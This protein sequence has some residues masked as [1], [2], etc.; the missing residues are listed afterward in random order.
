MKIKNLLPSFFIL[1]LFSYLAC[2]P[3]TAKVVQATNDQPATT[4]TTTTTTTTTTTKPNKPLTTEANETFSK[5]IPVD[6]EIRMGTLDNGL[7]YYIKKN[8][9]PENR[10]ELRLALNAGAMQ[11][12]DDQ[13]VN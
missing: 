3:K 4:V 10:A 5:R 6:P 9:K 13:K 7:K 12:D 11:E 2:T 8:T 1:L